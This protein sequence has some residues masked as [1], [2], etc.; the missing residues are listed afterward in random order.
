MLVQGNQAPKAARGQLIDEQCVG[1]FIAR[2][3]AVRTVHGLPLRPLHERLGL[4]NT[5]GH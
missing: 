4:G 2:K 5:I 3:H 1:R